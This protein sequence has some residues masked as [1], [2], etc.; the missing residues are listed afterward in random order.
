MKK[1]RRSTKEALISRFIENH[2]N[3]DIFK[4][5]MVCELQHREIITFSWVVLCM[6]ICTVGW[7]MLFLWVYPWALAFNP[8]GH[9]NIILCEVA[10][11]SCFPVNN[12]SHNY[13]TPCTTFLKIFI[14]YIISCNC[15]YFIFLL[16]MHMKEKLENIVNASN[17]Y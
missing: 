4:K 9:S 8:V 11:V 16:F 2:Y 3:G 5:F 1:Q 12:V 7:C 14:L 6:E 10:S 15:K 13:V 17:R